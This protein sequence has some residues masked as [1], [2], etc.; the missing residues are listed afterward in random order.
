M[1]EAAGLTVELTDDAVAVSSPG[2]G[3]IVAPRIDELTR[4][5]LSSKADVVSLTAKSSDPENARHKPE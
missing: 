1:F 2:A 5:L 3:K 4:Q